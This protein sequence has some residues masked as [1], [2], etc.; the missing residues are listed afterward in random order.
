MLGFPSLEPSISRVR[1]ISFYLNEY[2]PPS[3]ITFTITITSSK[4]TF[5]VLRTCIIGGAY[6][7]C[8]VGFDPE[9]N[10]ES[11]HLEDFHDNVDPEDM[12][13][14]DTCPI[15]FLEMECSTHSGRIYETLYLMEDSWKTGVSC[16]HETWQPAIADKLWELGK[17]SFIHYISDNMEDDECDDM[18]LKASDLFINV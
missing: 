7:A 6:E 4:M 1:T 12:K 10:L 13:G 14:F 17:E 11:Y 9:D 16:F 5:D 2:S 3:H 15:S 18:I 8:G